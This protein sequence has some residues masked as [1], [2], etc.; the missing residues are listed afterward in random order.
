MKTCQYCKANFA[1][2][3]AY[4]IHLGIGAPDF[5]PCNNAEEMTAKGMQFKNGSWSIDEILIVRQNNWTY[6]AK[7]YPRKETLGNLGD[8]Q[9]CL[10][11]G[12]IGK[13]AA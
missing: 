13:V 5:H 6:L 9:D 12:I 8:C 11:I 4:Q 10:T 1:N 2:E 3:D 7:G